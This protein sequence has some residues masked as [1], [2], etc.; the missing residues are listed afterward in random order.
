MS[1]KYFNLELT[2]DEITALMSALQSVDVRNEKLIQRHQNVSLPG[3]YNKLVS[4]ANDIY[5][6]PV[7]LAQ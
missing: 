7:E 1:N 4:A 5:V 6:T 3:L 2:F